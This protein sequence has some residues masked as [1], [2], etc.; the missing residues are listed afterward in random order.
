MKI[1]FMQKGFSL[2]KLALLLVTPFKY[3]WEEVEDDWKVFGT[4]LI[5]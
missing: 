3:N 5:S 1:R 4:L 2:G